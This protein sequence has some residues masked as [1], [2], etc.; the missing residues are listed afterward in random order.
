NTAVV[1][2]LNPNNSGFA[3]IFQHNGENWNRIAIKGMDFP[4][5]YHVFGT[6]LDMQENEIFIGGYSDYNKGYT[7]GFVY[8]YTCEEK[9]ACA[10]ITFPVNGLADVETDLSITWNSADKASGYMIF[11]GSCPG[12]TDLTDSL[13]AGQT[14]EYVLENLPYRDT[15]YLKIVPYNTS[16]FATE[17]QSVWFV[18][19]DFPAPPA[20]T[21]LLS[22]ISEAT[23]I[24]VYTDLQWEKIPDATGYQITVGNC[25]G[26]NN[27]LDSLLV[28]D[29]DFVDPGILPG[30]DTIFV[31]IIP[32]NDGGMASECQEAFFVTLNDRFASEICSYKDG[33]K[34]FPLLSEQQAGFGSAVDLTEN[35]LVVSSPG[36]ASGAATFYQR[37]GSDWRELNT[38]FPENGFS[39]GTDVAVDGEYAAVT[40]ENDW[41]NGVYAGAAYIY[42]KNENGWEQ[43]Q[44]I[45]GDDGRS[46]DYFGRAVDLFGEYMVVGCP[47]DDTIWHSGGSAYIFRLEGNLW[48]QDTILCPADIGVNDY[49]GS[50]VAIHGDFMIISA[51]WHYTN[52][53]A[54]IYKRTGKKW[55]LHQKLT[56]G[57]F[58]ANQ[59]FG[60]SVAISERF[61]VVTSPSLFTGYNKGEIFIY[62]LR[63]DQ[64]VMTD[65]YVL[66]SDNS[67]LNW[68]KSAVSVSGEQVIIGGETAFYLFQYDGSWK[69]TKKIFP[70]GIKKEDGFSQTLAMQNGVI[71]A[72]AS[73]AKGNFDGSGVIYSYNCNTPD[74]AALLFPVPNSIQA[75]LNPVLSW[76]QPL[77][78]AGM[79]L[80]IGTCPGCDDILEL[81]DI[82][83]ADT[84]PMSFNLPQNTLIYT[85]LRPYNMAG[86]QTECQIYS[87]RTMSISEP[88]EC[89]SLSFPMTQ[90]SISRL[91]YIRWEPVS[92]ALGYRI[93]IGS[94]AFCNDIA[95]ITTDA[96]SD[97]YVDIDTSGLRVY[98]TITP[99]NGNHF[100]ESCSSSSFYLLED[101][102]GESS[103]IRH[104]EFRPIQRFSSLSGNDTISMNGPYCPG[105]VITFIGKIR[106]ESRDCQKLHGI[107]PKLGS[108]WDQ[109]FLFLENPRLITGN[110]KA[111]EY[112]SDV[113][114]TARNPDL[115][116][117]SIPDGKTRLCHTLYE[118]DCPCNG[119]LPEGALL[120]PGWF[121]TIPAAACG[122]EEHPNK[123]LGMPQICHTVS[124]F[125]FQFKLKVKEAVETLPC[126]ET[127]S[128]DFK[129][130]LFTDN[131]TGCLSNPVESRMFPLT[132]YHQVNCDMSI[133]EDMVSEVVTE[134]FLESSKSHLISCFPNPVM[135]FLTV[136]FFL[137]KPEVVRFD[138]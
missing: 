118:P 27:I 59:H 93:D 24:S 123:G 89:T 60:T 71:V 54:Y 14:N 28:G 115:C 95:S 16:G 129:F 2:T 130:Y 7:R 125:S 12:C 17:C 104:F 136:D 101:P 87:F 124:T 32:F 62:E 61:A 138:L 88:L 51:T 65:G 3:H 94:C 6:G 137:L 120:P 13:D 49:F 114:T 82:R 80:S 11:A 53:A 20:C 83:G 76:S 37:Q 66:T 33:E 58:S 39:F 110:G 85:T 8:Y 84:Y 48:V 111:F 131:G 41:G 86:I 4:S 133:C 30:N 18:T 9:P 45:L 47:G 96:F 67:S 10:E 121:V 90:D 97:E 63:G 100:A 117:L 21:D 68:A 36:Y 108:G 132:S 109:E 99:F 106:F 5:F 23:G 122:F 78:T 56:P 116:V 22:P 102:Y 72:A 44:K 35:H 70:A 57:N 38:V 107:I 43:T 15:V 73:K 26:C 134:Q 19:E 103:C 135:D 79:Q 81:T 75:P 113:Q 29:V 31:R 40:D 34:I 119:G 98:I 50:S 25:S 105:E 128:L 55:N 92:N 64:W 52:G 127:G 69:E 91:S 126:E 74:C 46:A 42:R 112:H 1:T 77:E